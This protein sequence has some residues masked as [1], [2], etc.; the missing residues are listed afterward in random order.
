MARSLDTIHTVF[1]SLIKLKPWEFDARCTA[2]PWREDVF[3]DALRRPLVIGVLV[4]DEVVRPHPPITRVL[5]S[6]IELFRAAGHEIVE[7]DA[8]LHAECIELMVSAAV[9]EI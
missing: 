3:Q 5:K 6:A 8:S 2:I 1:K 4:D 7:W 9:I